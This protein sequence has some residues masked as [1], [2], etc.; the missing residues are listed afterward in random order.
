MIYLFN[1]VWR[2]ADKRF[3]WAYGLFNSIP[4]NENGYPLRASITSQR[5][6]KQNLQR[7]ETKPAKC[8]DE[9]Q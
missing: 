4:F 8:I 1:V 9:N 3:C 7:N 6:I 5:L 2:L